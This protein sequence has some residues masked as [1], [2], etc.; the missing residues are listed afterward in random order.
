MKA[1]INVVNIMYESINIKN[2]NFQNKNKNE[3]V[4]CENWHKKMLATHI[5]CCQCF[6]MHTT[7]FSFYKNTFYKNMSLIFGLKLR[8]NKKNWK[9]RI[10][11]YGGTKC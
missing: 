9:P 1:I 10:L 8:T 7:L 11:K 6:V 5:Y 2:K 4:N 3:A